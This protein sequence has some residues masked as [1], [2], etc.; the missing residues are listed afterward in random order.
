M[1]DILTITLNPALDLATSAARIRPDEK[2]RCA[3]P[4]TDPGGGGLNVARAIHQLGANARA[5]VAL[6]GD[7]GAAVR[8]LLENAG[9]D[10]I[11]HDAPGDTRQNLVVNDLTTNEQFR[12]ML[13]GPDWGKTHID[14]VRAAIQTNIKAGGFVVLSGSGPNGA[15]PDL[16][17]DICQDLLD[18][19]VEVLIDTSGPALAHLAAGQDRPPLVLRM[20]QHEAETLARRPLQSCKDSAEFALR[21]VRQGAARTVIIARGADGS[22]LADGKR[23]LAVN[24]ANVV[25]RSRVG[26][27]DSFLGGLTMGLARDEP[28]EEAL[29]MGAAAASAACVT[30]GTQLCLP[31]DFERLLQE[32]HVEA[33]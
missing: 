22:V 3:S 13:A 5:F 15:A 8:H 26:A 4:E 23:Q 12:F 29:R 21:L 28:M 14:A 2:L 18:A 7:A 10:L 27:G 9:L 33:L 25:V 17:A 1:R 24:A 20:D 30:T 19:D 6:G 11:V 32:T 16:Y 31:A